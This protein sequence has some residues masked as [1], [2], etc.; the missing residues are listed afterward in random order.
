MIRLADAP[1]HLADIAAVVG[2]APK[3]L[4]RYR[5]L[6]AGLWQESSPFQG[7]GVAV[8]PYPEDPDAHFEALKGLG[9]RHVLL[10][11][12]PWDNEHEAEEALAQRLCDAGIEVAFTLP[13]NRELVTDRSENSA[14]RTRQP[15][16][17][18]HN[19]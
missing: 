1:D 18:I 8:R 12:H 2:A 3:M 11:L 17:L 4:A 19:R 10:R 9:V 7:I 5:E 14:M 15:P 13:Q 16:S 6:K